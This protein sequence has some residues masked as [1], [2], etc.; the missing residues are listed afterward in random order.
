[1]KKRALSLLLALVLLIFNGILALVALLNM[2][3]MLTQVRVTAEIQYS[4]FLDLYLFVAVLEFV[5]L[6]FIM[7]AIT[8][9]SISGERERQTLDLML[10]TKMTPMQI[11][12]GKL[13]ASM[14]NKEISFGSLYKMAIYTRTAPL[15][16][17]MVYMWIPVSI[18]F[19]VLINMGISCFYM[20]KAIEVAAEDRKPIE[21][22]L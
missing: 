7:P 22:I 3:S 17:K 13:M 19:F 1:M 16:L 20:W 8:A 12:M 2:Y 15:L 18:P 10:S 9:G 21:I 6:V 4:S 5:M 11:V 14:Q